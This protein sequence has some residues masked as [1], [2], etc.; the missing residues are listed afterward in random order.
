M[1]FMMKFKK[2]YPKVSVLE[3]GGNI[4][5]LILLPFVLNVGPKNV[6]LR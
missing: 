6:V 1:I 3:H 4:F 5:R 2:N